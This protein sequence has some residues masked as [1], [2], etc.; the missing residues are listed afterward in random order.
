M[1][2]VILVSSSSSS[3]SG[4]SQAEAAPSRCVEGKKNI[5]ALPVAVS[6]T[7]W[8]VAGMGFFSYASTKRDLHLGLGYFGLE[9]VGASVAV[10]VVITGLEAVRAL[11]QNGCSAAK[12]VFHKSISET[13]LIRDTVFPTL[14]RIGQLL[15]HE[16]CQSRIAPS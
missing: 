3:S 16:G 10:S 1:S 4:A 9:T 7:G 6:L 12:E 2:T 13:G 8:I 11:C 15:G 5:R 14:C